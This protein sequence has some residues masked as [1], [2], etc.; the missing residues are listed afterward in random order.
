MSDTTVGEIEED[1]PTKTS[2]TIFSQL[3]QGQ[4][5]QLEKNFS[6][7][8]RL[9]WVIILMSLWDTFMIVFNTYGTFTFGLGTILMV[10]TFLSEQAQ[11]FGWNI[12][13]LQSIVALCNL[14]ILALFTGIVVA[15]TRR[16][17]LAYQVAMGLYFVDTFVFVQNGLWW[18]VASHL[19]F[20][21]LLNMG[22]FHLMILKKLTLLGYLPRT[23]DAT[24][25][26]EIVP[27][28]ILT[29]L[30]AT[31]VTLISTPTSNMGGMEVNRVQVGSTT[32]PEPFDWKMVR[33]GILV[34]VVPILIVGFVLWL[35]LP[36]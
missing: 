10:A 17:V 22:H 11:Q 21:F 27:A 4:L 19:F 15:A 34:F 26:P 31:S 32:T 28:P 29:A 7:T 33:A 3:T 30:A 36:K 14:V 20:L 16:H 18:S 9:F 24:T 23:A 5:L 12:T 25:I 35:I 1:F 2:G 6:N 13:T 8:S